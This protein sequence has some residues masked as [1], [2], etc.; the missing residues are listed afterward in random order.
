[1]GFQL[2]GQSGL[3][4]GSTE[5]KF[6]AITLETFE[7]VFFTFSGAKKSLLITPHKKIL[8]L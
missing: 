5:K 3:F 4:F 2:P 1:M 6:G 7:G 8:S